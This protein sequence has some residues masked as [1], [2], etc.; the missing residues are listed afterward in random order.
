LT[1]DSRYSLQADTTVLA[2]GHENRRLRWL[3]K[4]PAEYRWCREIALLSIRSALWK[5]TSPPH[6]DTSRQDSWVRRRK[7]KMATYDEVE[8]GILNVQELETFLH[9]FLPRLSAEDL[10]DGD[11]LLPYV[12]QFGLRP[13]DFLNG[14]DLT[15]DESTHFEASA[16]EHDPLVLTRPGH[17]DAIGLVIYCVRWGRWKICLECGWFYCRIVI[18]R[19]F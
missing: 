8:S 3:L 10:R 1:A 14:V 7:D 18:T 12:E 19:R 2:D 9:E 13:P 16:G 6:R 5:V 11:D 4:R 17:P 15:W